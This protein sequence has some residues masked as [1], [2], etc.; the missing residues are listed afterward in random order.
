MKRTYGFDAHDLPVRDID[1]LLPGD[2]GAARD[3][4]GRVVAMPLAA[5]DPALA[6]K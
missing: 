5:H 4:D 3:D 2:W 6:V 1:K